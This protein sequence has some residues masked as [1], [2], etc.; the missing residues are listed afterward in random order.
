M[1]NH[2]LKALFINCCLERSPT[3]SQTRR[4]MDLVIRVMT[5]NGV[6]ATCVRAADLDIPPGVHLDMTLHGCATD[7]WP[8]L[9]A[10]I[11]EADILVLGTPAWLGDKSSI[12]T[13]IIERMHG[14]S[15]AVSSAGARAY[16]GRTAGCV[17]SGHDDG[18]KLC[19]M[20]ILYALQHLGYVI[21]PQADAGWVSERGGASPFT[22][23]ASDDLPG[24][25]AQRN[26]TFMAWNLMR[27][28]R[29]LK[30][31]D[32]GGATTVPLD[33]AP[34]RTARRR[35]VVPTGVETPAG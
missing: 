13:R 2:D 3:E 23:G 24:D 34:R 1:D 11:V 33:A 32:G 35:R 7:P 29:L 25:H 14:S 5:D 21:P 9:H 30:D 17:I 6:D 10:R 27:M 12:C 20:N 31:I 4:L 8:A 26:T 16:Q 18:A 22:D 15:E 28:A 19:A